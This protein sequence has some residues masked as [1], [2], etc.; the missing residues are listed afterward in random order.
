M[1]DVLSDEEGGGPLEPASR[2]V[3]SAFPESRD[4]RGVGRAGPYRVIFLVFYGGKRTSLGAVEPDPFG[5]LPWGA[6]AQVES[7]PSAPD[8]LCPTCGKHT[9]LSQA[10][11]APLQLKA[12][13][14]GR[15]LGRRLWSQT[16]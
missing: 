2:P 8:F 10:P 6:G 12:V 14:P 4:L 11:V 7:P 15:G 1:G 5:S 3:D 13:P 9:H 16:I